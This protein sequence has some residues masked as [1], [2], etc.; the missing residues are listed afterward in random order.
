MEE[1]CDDVYLGDV[2]ANNGK[3]TKNLKKRISHGVGVISQVHNLLEMISF[4]HHSVEIG[5]LLRES[6]FLSSI[7]YNMEVWYGM[8]SDEVGELEKL[9]LILLRKILRVPKLLLRRHFI[10]NLE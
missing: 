2:I 3:N 4:G 6:V 9:D 10:S 1:V 8:S 7:L 5:L